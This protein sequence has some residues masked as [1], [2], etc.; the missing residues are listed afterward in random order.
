MTVV[1]ESSGELKVQVMIRNPITGN[2]L[3]ADEG[4]EIITNEYETL[5][6]EPVIQHERR[7]VADGLWPVRRD[8]GRLHRQ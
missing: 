7:C 3:A 6:W 2:T 8:H 5:C 1:G 4:Y